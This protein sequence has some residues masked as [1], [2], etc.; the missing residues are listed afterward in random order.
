ML[1]IYIYRINDGYECHTSACFPMAGSFLLELDFLDLLY[2]SCRHKFQVQYACSPL[3]LGVTVNQKQS[4]QF[5]DAH[6]RRWQETAQF[7]SICID[8]IFEF[9]CLA[10]VSV[11]L[12]RPSVGAGND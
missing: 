12:R 8:F 5:Q 11:W 7:G 3:L 2:L 1:H 6:E 9:R 10:A 4:H